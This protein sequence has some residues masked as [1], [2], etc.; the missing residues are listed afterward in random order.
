MGLGLLLV[1]RASSHQDRGRWQE[2]ARALVVVWR[3]RWA[4]V[5]ARSIGA[6]GEFKGATPAVRVMSAR[7]DLWARIA[8]ESCWLVG[9][10]G[11]DARK[12]SIGV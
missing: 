1:W 2:M 9:I 10:G 3:R 12:S 5:W 8:S 11:S 7:E 4:R 6:I